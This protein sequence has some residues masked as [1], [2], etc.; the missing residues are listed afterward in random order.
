MEPRL[1]ILGNE[2]E[3]PP[4]AF[5]RH[6][7][8]P[9][10]DGLCALQAMV[11]RLTRSSLPRCLQSHGI[12]RLPDV[13]GS[14]PRKKVS[15]YPIGTIRMDI[16]AVATDGGK[17]CMFD[18]IGRTSKFAFAELHERATRATLRTNA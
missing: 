12:S 14:K 3:A 9:L 1:T 5:R 10:D 18:A 16:A 6:R 17:L 8:L 13:E 4:V 7:P 2:D 11:S 15:P